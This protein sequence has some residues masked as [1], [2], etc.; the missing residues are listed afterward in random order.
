[1]KLEDV[2]LFCE[3]EQA[4]VTFYTDAG[5]VTYWWKGWAIGPATAVWGWPADAPDPKHQE[6]LNKTQKFKVTTRDGSEKVLSREEFLKL[7]L[8]TP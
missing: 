1:M 6:A 3:C 5:E 4:Y 7:L 8:P 2:I